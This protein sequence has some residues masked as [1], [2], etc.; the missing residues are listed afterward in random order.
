MPIQIDDLRP[1]DFTIEVK[2][3]SLK[4]KPLRLSHTL[5]LSKVGQ[6]FQEGKASRQEIIEAEN[7]LDWVLKEIIPELGDQKL[8]ISSTMKII[9]QL[10]ETIQ[11]SDNKELE[12]QGV[13]F[14]DPKDEVTG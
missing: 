11:P 12:K 13:T 4:C 8:D 10:M 14:S 3:V 9:E 5:T 6:I 2:G 1:K 7:D